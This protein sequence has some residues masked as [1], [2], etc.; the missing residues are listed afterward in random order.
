MYLRAKGRLSH[1]LLSQTSTLFINLLSNVNLNLIS[2]KSILQHY[3][4]TTFCLQH[5]ETLY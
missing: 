2:I 5:T 1:T 3:R 4:E